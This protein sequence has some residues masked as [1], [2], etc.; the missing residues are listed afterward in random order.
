MTVFDLEDIAHQ[1]ISSQTVTKVILG[2]L[3]LV[4]LLLSKLKFEVVDYHRAWSHL[5]FYAV[6]AQ[7][8]GNYFYQAT[9]WPSC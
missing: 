9:V 2:F 3:V 5:F 8:I 1:A 6:N 4:G 7:R